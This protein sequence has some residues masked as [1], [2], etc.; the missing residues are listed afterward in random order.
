MHTSGAVSGE[1]ALF[2]TC[3][4]PFVLFLGFNLLLFIAENSWTWDHPS[5][6]WWQRAPEMVLYPAQVIVCG[7]YLWSVR[8]GVS[9]RASFGHCVLGIL[10]GVAGIAVWLLPYVNGWIPAE[11]G[12]SP[13]RIFGEDSPMVPVQYIFRFL[14]AVVIVA[15]VEEL[16]WRGYLMRWCINRDFPQSVPIGQGSWLSY[17]VVTLAFMLAH[18]PVDYAG[19]FVYGTFAYLLV[20][21]TRCLLPVILMHAVANLVMGI[22]ALSLDLPHL[23]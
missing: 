18:R 8:R 10:A 13:E 23:W 22:C 11:G 4:C 20:L 14:R 2:R 17:A 19:A 1:A 16:F 7:A 15:L 6:P 21:Q 5:A 12:F 9:W 3:V